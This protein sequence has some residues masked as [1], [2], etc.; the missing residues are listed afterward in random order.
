MSR[1]ILL[2]TLCSL[3]TVF[4]TDAISSAFQQSNNNPRPQTRHC[5]VQLA[6]RT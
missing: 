3:I 2:V 5:A 4:P 6:E 1:R